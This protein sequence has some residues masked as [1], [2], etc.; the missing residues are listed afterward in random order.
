[1]HLG[2][3]R[4]VLAI[5]GAALVGVVIAARWW[6]CRTARP[7]PPARTAEPPADRVEELH[8]AFRE[9]SVREPRTAEELLEPYRSRLHPLRLTRR[10]S[11]GPADSHASNRTAP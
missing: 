8:L 6:A 1:M 3:S 7:T 11:S 5:A 10:P 4:E 2:S 9:T